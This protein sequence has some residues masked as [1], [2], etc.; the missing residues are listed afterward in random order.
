MAAQISRYDEVSFL[1]QVGCAAVLYLLDQQG[2][3]CL[4]EYS[5]CL[6]QEHSDEHLV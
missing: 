3:H 6:R 5:Q 2:I 4:V 1:F